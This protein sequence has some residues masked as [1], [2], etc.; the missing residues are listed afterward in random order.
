L[1]EK[2]SHSRDLSVLI[3]LVERVALI[4]HGIFRI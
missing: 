4:K 1:K 3:E 2:L